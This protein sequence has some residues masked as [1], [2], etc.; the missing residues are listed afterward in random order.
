MLLQ[1]RAK[2]YSIWKN[3][4][5]IIVRRLAIGHRVLNNAYVDPRRMG[6]F[7]C[8]P[9]TRFVE[10]GRIFCTAITRRTSGSE[11]RSGH[12]FRTITL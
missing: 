12:P 7:F 8:Y 3:P 11:E 10:K 1:R 6:S 4:C 5:L 2:P 9:T